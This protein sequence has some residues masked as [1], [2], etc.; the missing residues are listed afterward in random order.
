MREKAARRALTAVANFRINRHKAAQKNVSPDSEIA[1]ER[2][3]SQSVR[4]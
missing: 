1:N 3:F 2:N 4:I